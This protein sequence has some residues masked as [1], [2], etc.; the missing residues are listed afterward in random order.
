MLSQVRVTVSG[1]AETD[2]PIQS[3]LANFPLA[4]GAIL[5]HDLY[6]EG[7][8]ALA[9]LLAERGYLDAAFDTAEIRVDQAAYTAEV[10]LY[11]TSGA[12]FLFGPVTFNQDIVDLAL[13]EGYVT[14]Q[15]GDTFELSKL[16]ELRRGLSSSPFFN[17]VEVLP[18]REEARDRQVP[19][20]VNAVPRKRQRYEFGIGYGTDTQFRGSV[21]ADFR[22]LNR[23]G[24]N[25][26][27]RL[28]VSQIRRSI[29]GQYR[30]P[31]EYPETASYALLVFGGDISPNWSQTLRGAVGVSRSQLRGPLREVFSLTYDAQDWEIA[32]QPGNSGLMILGASYVWTRAQD[33]IVPMSGVLLQ[34]D[35]QG[36]LDEV[37]STASFLRLDATSKFIRG[38]GSK[39]RLIGRADLGKIFTSQFGQLPPTQRY[40]T[41]GDRTVRGYAFESLGPR[42][43]Q[44]RIVGG[45]VHIVVS[46]ELDYGILEKWRAATFVDAGNAVA[47]DGSFALAVGAGIG[48]RW[49]SPV[50]LVRLDLA[51]G[52]D[53]PS[54][55]IRIH[56]NFGPDI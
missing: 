56:F 34:L 46:G 40:V 35:G 24:H 6:E 45:D 17:Q 20:E 54:R 5:R 14:F 51:Y 47:S 9:S 13:L 32:N 36:S 38:L 16:V 4:A 33:Q 48:V 39:A 42:D 37:L 18:K 49:V 30:F 11:I 28:E 21:E 29:A 55:G 23:R 1:D 22:R 15:P 10:V 19:I 12:R 43:A 50:G 26:T 52:F 3:A 27:V 44:G 41:G 8:L 2:E 25:A 7:K 53:D 31:P